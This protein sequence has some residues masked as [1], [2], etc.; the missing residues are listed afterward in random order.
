MTIETGSAQN[1]SRSAA[2]ESKHGKAKP[3]DAH[4]HGGAGPGGFMAILASVETPEVATVGTITENP[5]ALALALLRR[6]AAALKGA[7]AGDDKGLG[8]AVGDL[9]PTAV[10][11]ALDKFLQGGG[12]DVSVAATVPLTPPSDALVQPE[13]PVDASALLAQ[14]AQWAATPTANSE[15][16]KSNATHGLPGIPGGPAKLA[17]GTTKPDGANPAGIGLAE[18]ATGLAGK[19]NKAQ[20]DVLARLADAQ[21][22]LAAPEQASAN[23]SL[24]ADARLAQAVQKTA[25]TLMSPLAAA[26]AV[27]STVAPARREDMARER[28]AFRSNAAESTAPGHTYLPSAAPGSVISAPDPVATVDTYVAEKVAYWISN[29]VQNAEMKLEGIGEMPVEVSIR[30]QGNEAHIAFRSDELQAREALENASLHLKELLQREGL[31][32]SGVSVGTAGAGDAGGQERKSRQGARQ[33][34]IAT[35]QAAQT[36][37][38]AGARRATGGALDLFV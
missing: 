27:A 29:D 5:A 13:L 20:K 18:G 4:G 32:L 33:S 1:T 14:A 24:V 9:D 30:M 22:A 19:A 2:T 31:V 8:D 21:A 10:D 37:G 7:G 38:A 6:A 12:T 16:S 28:S 11:A 3:G 15:Q 23:T 17:L 25:E 35:V 26:Q 36:D 34:G